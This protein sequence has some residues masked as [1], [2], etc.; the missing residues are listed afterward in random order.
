MKKPYQLPGDFIEALKTRPTAEIESIFDE[1][2]K[3]KLAEIPGCTTTDE[4]VRVQAQ[5][6]Y[7]Q[8]L[9]QFFL[10]EMQRK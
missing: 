7:A 3:K 6:K 4:L 1:L 8:E 5:A 10:A 2:V 9:L